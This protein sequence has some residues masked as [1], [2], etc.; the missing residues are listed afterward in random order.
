M[1]NSL[2][3]T[4]AFDDDVRTKVV[5]FA[6]R[7][8]GHLLPVAF[9]NRPE[10]WHVAMFVDVDCLAKPSRVGPFLVR[11]MS[12]EEVREREA[13]RAA[14]VLEVFELMR[15]AGVRAVLFVL[16]DAH[17]TVSSVCRIPS[18]GRNHRG[19]VPYAS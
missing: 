11:H 12:P 2:E 14:E 19:E 18:E 7:I 6:L 9:S 10:G 16:K 8:A 1:P 5:R 13:E 17:D 15:R 3:T 4:P